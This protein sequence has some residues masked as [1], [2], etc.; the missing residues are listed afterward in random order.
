MGYMLYINDN[1][2]APVYS[3]N[4]A[5]Q[6]AAPHILNRASLRIESF[7]APAPSQIWTYDYK[8]MDW[9]EK[10]GRSQFCE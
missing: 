3:L 4:E 9:V 5:K 7:V 8:E 10:L 2:E 6:S 1:P